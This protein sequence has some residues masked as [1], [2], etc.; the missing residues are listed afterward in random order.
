MVVATVRT[1][2]DSATRPAR[3]G[4]LRRLR[5]LTAVLLAGLLLVS[6]SGCATADWLSSWRGKSP[7]P[8]QV[9]VDSMSLRNGDPDVV[10]VLPA[11]G[12]AGAELEA[13]KRFYYDGE[14]AKAAPMFGRLAGDSKNL[15]Q[16]VEEALYYQADCQRLQGHYSAAAELYNKLVGAYP[17]GKHANQAREHLF[18]I[19]NYWLDDT[20]AYMEACREKKEGKRWFV[21]PMAPVHF[22]KTKPTFDTEG[23][24]IRMLEQVYITDPQGPLA[25]K[26]LF[27]LGS[28]KF[29]RED[30]RDS[31]HYFS[32]LVT[33]HPNGKLAPEALRYSIICKQ[34]S[35]GGS[36]YDL[37]AL[38]EARNL[39]QVAHVSYPELAKER[40]DFLK[41]QV[42][43]IT[44][45]QADADFKV[46]E[47]YKRTGHPGAAYFYYE[48][49]RR[50]YPGTEYAAKAG[51]RMTELKQRV[52]R[53]KAKDQAKE[54][55]DREAVSRPG[56]AALE[57]APAPRT[58]TPG[59]PLG[60]AVPGLLPNGLTN[61]TGPNRP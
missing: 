48:L 18:N 59:A 9:P 19:A 39:V 34:M 28:I 13:A 47:F 26:A 60:G 2:A 31:D 35:T 53:E 55:K 12:K 11:A 16:I 7:D 8:P 15:V 14:Y 20:R 1:T 38:G 58:F 25:E 41:R 50:R 5:A 24:A 49:V 32:Q 3:S 21:P 57:T 29:F 22:D 46:A 17:M 36:E 43:S 4:P 45:Q 40:D 37:R 27:Y 42:F 6:T 51:E 10:E 52:D 56:G 61:G 23:H 33:H 54:Q 44:Q 30:Y